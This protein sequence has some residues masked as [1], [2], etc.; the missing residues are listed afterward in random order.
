MNTAQID[1]PT[2]SPAMSEVGGTGANNPQHQTQIDVA[3]DKTF[4]ARVET[5]EPLPPAIQMDHTAAATE[6]DLQKSAL[7][8][9]ETGLGRVINGFC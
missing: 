4:E 3:R 8:T 6:V 2:L 5:R 9:Y 1:S 7:A